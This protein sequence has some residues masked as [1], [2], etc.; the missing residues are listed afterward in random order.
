MWRS[1]PAER[2]AGYHTVFHRVARALQCGLR[3][4]VDARWS[5]VR[6]A[7]NVTF[8]ASVLAWIMSDPARFNTISEFT[9]D[10]LSM[11]LMASFFW[12]ARRNLPSRLSRMKEELLARGEDELAKEFAPRRARRLIMRVRRHRRVIT[13]L[14]SAEQ[15]MMDEALRYAAALQ[16]DGAERRSAYGELMKSW[17]F[18]LKRLL[19]GFDFSDFAPVLFIALTRELAIA[20]AEFRA[21]ESLRAA[22]R[23]RSAASADKRYCPDAKPAPNDDRSERLHSADC[24]SAGSRGS[25][26][27]DPA[28]ACADRH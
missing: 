14:I 19:T 21:A 2:T 16:L 6:S 28:P 25:S 5:A 23:N 24:V 1:A 9:Y 22:G 4:C 10:V 12:S 27:R 18:T 3:S 20:H 26:Q 11:P 17:R 15:K 7:A 8:T 13:R